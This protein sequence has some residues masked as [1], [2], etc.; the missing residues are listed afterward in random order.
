MED[1]CGQ[2]QDNQK[3]RVNGQDGLENRPCIYQ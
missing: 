2:S 1:L 3:T